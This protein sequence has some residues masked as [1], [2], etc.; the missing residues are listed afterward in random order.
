MTELFEKF[1]VNRDPRWPVISKLVGASLVLHLTFLWA[2][3]YVPALRDTVNIAA[4]IASTK[5]V[6]RDYEA[7]RI[8]D[9]V[10]IVQLNEKFRYPDGYFALG[11]QIDGQLPAQAAANDPFAPKIISQAGSTRDVVPEASPSPTPEASPSPAASPSASASPSAAVAQGAANSN[12]NTTPLTQE[13]AQKQLEKTAEANNVP[14]P[15][16]NQINKKPLKDFAAY[17]NDLKTQ[18][19]LDLDKPFEIVIEAQQIH[20]DACGLPQLVV[21]GVFDGHC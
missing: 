17:A 19:K 18:G 12:Q 7:T 10:Q 16:E 9:D 20:R 21:N 4:L 14:L 5:F 3:I 13:E 1:E 8:T 15:D 11:A 6:D 2:V